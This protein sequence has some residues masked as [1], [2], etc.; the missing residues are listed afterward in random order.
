MTPPY[1]AGRPASDN[2][3]N[4]R[5][6]LDFIELLIEGHYLARPDFSGPLADALTRLAERLGRRSEELLAETT[7]MSMNASVAMAT[8]ARVAGDVSD[9]EN[10]AQAMAGEVER[11]AEMSSDLSDS[12]RATSEIVQSMRGVTSELSVGIHR[13][14]ASMGDMVQQVHD[15]I[16]DVQTLGSASEHIGEILQTIEAIAKQTNLLAL[17][18]TIEAARAGEAGKGFAVVAGEV[19][20]LANQTARSTDDIRKRIAVLKDGVKE[21]VSQVELTESTI[22]VGQEVIDR[23]GAMVV[24]IEDTMANVEGHMNHTTETLNEQSEAMTEISGGVN[25]VARMANDNT[26]HVGTVVES[27]SGSEAVIADQFKALEGL[28][29][30]RYVLYRAKS[31]HFLWKKHLSEMMVGISRL[32]EAEL[33]DHHS[34]RLGRWYD[35]VEGLTRS[36]PDFIAID[37]PHQQVHAKGREAARLYAEGDIDGAHTAFAE[38]DQASEDVVRL[39]DRLIAKS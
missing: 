4:A 9:L 6:A 34:C 30:P 25:Q 23:I 39:I 33:S 8:V 3:D 35:A 5:A 38:M 37:R 13:G 11:M 1:E 32:T 16:D 17:N 22:K 24:E 7:E 10:G 29:I 21:T 19:K 14:V 36:D 2:E 15:L 18:A 20:N 27:V 31:D 28:E 12:C 26:A